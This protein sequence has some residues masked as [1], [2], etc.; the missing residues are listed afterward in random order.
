M[1][2]CNQCHSQFPNYTKIDGKTHNISSRHYCLLC[3]PFK[4]KAK[5]TR[6]VGDTKHC[7]KCGLDLPLRNFYIRSSARRHG[8]AYPYCRKC[9]AFEASQRKREFKRS[10]VAY[11][12]GQCRICEYNR[13]DGAMDFHHKEPEH[14]DFQISRVRCTVLTDAIKHE[15][16]K[17]ELLCCR[18]HREVHDG[19]T[20]LP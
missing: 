16:D 13:C 1:P 4:A 8:H 12:G 20:E 11:K 18:C 15:L 17:C 3:S 5:T 7:G 19:V 14:K 10:C 6:P 9:S 2:T